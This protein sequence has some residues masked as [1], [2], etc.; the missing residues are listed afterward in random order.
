MNDV[1]KL[2]HEMGENKIQIDLLAGG[3]DRHFKLPNPRTMCVL[4][5]TLQNAP[6]N[7]QGISSTSSDLVADPINKIMLTKVPSNSPNPLSRG[8]SPDKGQAL[9]RHQHLGPA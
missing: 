9:V 3:A 6:L 5:V 7:L 1:G 8:A 2:Y 4:K